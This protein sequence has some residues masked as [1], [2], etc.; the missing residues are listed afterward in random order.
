[1]VISH[2]Y[3]LQRTDEK[4]AI[5]RRCIRMSSTFNQLYIDILIC[6]AFVAFIILTIHYIKKFNRDKEAQL[7]I[8]IVTSFS[9]IRR[10]EFREF[11]GF[12]ERTLG[13]IIF[14]HSTNQIIVFWRRTWSSSSLVNLGSLSKHDL[15]G[16]ENVI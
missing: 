5:A 2:F 8:R 16:S 9:G 1:M 14:P 11:P 4:G 13:T 12:R 7:V 10:G 15:D 6:S 3:F